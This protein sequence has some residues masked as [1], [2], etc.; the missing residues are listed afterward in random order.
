MV[1]F[2]KDGFIENE[3]SVWDQVKEKVIQEVLRGV[4][5]YHK[6]VLNLKLQAMD[7][8]MMDIIDIKLHTPSITRQLYSRQANTLVI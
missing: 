3:K 5:E 7:S 6:A 4:T 8:K 1:G 2:F